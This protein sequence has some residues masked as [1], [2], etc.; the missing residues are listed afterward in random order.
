M[1]SLENYLS[2]ELQEL[3]E[4]TMNGLQVLEDVQSD[5]SESDIQATGQD[6]FP[7][8]PQMPERSP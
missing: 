4:I 5:T 1:T 2:Q 7:N 8:A 6:S 3:R